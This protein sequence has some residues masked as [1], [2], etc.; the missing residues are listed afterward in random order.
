MGEYIRVG[1]ITLFNILTMTFSTIAILISLYSIYRNNRNQERQL[2]IGKIEEVLEIHHYLHEAYLGLYHCYLTLEILEDEILRQDDE[3]YKYNTMVLARQRELLLGHI[4]SDDELF[5]KLIRLDVL[6]SA[7]IVNDDLARKVEANGTMIMKTA[8][9]VLG[10]V[11]LENSAV[12]F[13]PNL[14]KFGDFMYR[15]E[16]ELVREMGLKTKLLT[17]EK[18]KIYQAK[19]FKKE[20][21]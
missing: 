9:V 18:F 7:Y 17:R 5:R 16:L 3:T 20:F 19:K 15:V 4:K 14:E 12:D 8:A 11:S 13:L 6:A 1:E 21:E 10:R 2:K